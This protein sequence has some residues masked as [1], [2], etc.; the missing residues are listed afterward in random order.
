M[1][2]R[3]ALARRSARIPGYRLEQLDDLTRHLPS[4]K[5]DEALLSFARFHPEKAEQRIREELEHLRS[6]GWAAEW[7]VHD[8]DEPPDLKARLEAQGLTC[9]H[10]EAL[11]VME[12]GASPP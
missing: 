3:Y 4:G 10:V 6:H 5:D 9:H 12:V 2:E 1:F 11:L 7:K 8:L